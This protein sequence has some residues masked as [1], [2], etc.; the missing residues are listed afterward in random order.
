MNAPLKF[1]LSASRRTDIPAFY[2]D[3]FMDRIA[4]GA[5]EVKNPYNAQIRH[6]AATAAT[7]H[8][9]V[10]WSKNFGPFLDGRFGERLKKMGFNLFFNFTLNSESAIL[11][12]N[13]PPLSNRLNQLSELAAT[14]P[15]ESIT[16]RF[17]PVC[18]YV[19]PMGSSMEN[20]GDFD[21]IT[22]H[23]G[24]LGITR[25]ITSFM[26]LYSK[27]QKR[28]AK[29]QSLSFLPIPI[30]EQGRMLGA[31]ETRL[32][33]FGL[34]LFICCE[35]ELLQ[36]LPPASTI[37]AAACIPN[38]LLMRLFGGTLS[39][40]KDAGQRVSAGCG[41]RVSV[42]IGAYDQHPCFH[43]CLYCYANP[44]APLKKERI[45]QSSGIA[46]GNE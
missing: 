40:K 46:R 28:A 31:M 23:A 15:P 3:W 36:S 18:R 32:K 25:C 22:E 19:T 39:L 16:W 38:D 1:V 37:K 11:E 41:C 43:N 27:V 4:N 20:F 29:A 42:D 44:S 30:E 12:P 35:K 21:K 14:Y 45:G 8:T 9:I 5:F 34:Q 17:D 2:M 6:V 33:A 10:F 24:N 7:V 26:D 13:V